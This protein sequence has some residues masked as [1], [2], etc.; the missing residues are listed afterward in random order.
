MLKEV[1]YA[2]EDEMIKSGL[3]WLAKT[4]VE[5]HKQMSDPKL[6]PD[7]YHH[8]EVKTDLCRILYT[9]S[10]WSVTPQS[11][12]DLS[13]SPFKKVKR[14]HKSAP[15]SAPSPATAASGA[16]KDEDAGTLQF[17]SQVLPIDFSSLPVAPKC[18][19]RNWLVSQRN[20]LTP[21]ALVYLTIACKNLHDDEN[22]KLAYARLNELSQTSAGMVNWDH[23]AVMAK[24]LG[25]QYEEYD[26]RFTPSE[27]T[28]LALTAVLDMEPDNFEKIEGIKRWLL[29]QRDQNGWQNT[30]TTSQVFLSLLKEELQFKSKQGQSADFAVKAIGLGHELLDLMYNSTNIYAA[31]QTTAIKPSAT[32]Q[33]VDLIKTGPGRLYYTSILNYMRRL[34]PGDQIAAKGYPSGLQISRKFYRLTATTAAD[35]SI[36]FHSN[37]ITDHK[38]KAGETIMMKTIV[39]SPVSLPYV[40]IEAAL[41]SGAEVVKDSRESS[42]ENPNENGTSEDGTKIEGDWSMPWWTHED[43]LDDRIVYFGASLPQGQ[44]EFHSMLRMELPGKLEVLPITLEGMYSDKIRAYSGLDEL[45]VTE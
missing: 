40:K 42:V 1:D 29:L 8:R 28:A 16:K 32:A 2:K 10:E 13:L 24:K 39:V 36:K 21:E 18:D 20:T 31:E 9:L 17:R 26:Y 15:Q 27:T 6:A 35:G 3:L 41:P 7:A 45:Q 22:A 30:K 19:V 44:S 38:L 25:L 5:G 33:D 12:Q 4:A 43:V 14:S 37:E 34:M 23:N 11:M